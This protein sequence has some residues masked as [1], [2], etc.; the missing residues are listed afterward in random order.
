LLSDQL[1]DEGNTQNNRNKKITA[2][3][4]KEQKKKEYAKELM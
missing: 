4:K 2:A 3:L 1:K